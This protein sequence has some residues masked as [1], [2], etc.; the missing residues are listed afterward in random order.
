MQLTPTTASPRLI[1]TKCST[2][3]PLWAIITS[4]PLS[5]SSP[6]QI[7]RQYRPS[8]AGILQSFLPKRKCS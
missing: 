6:I 4:K 2:K 1:S 5:N 7:F 3:W 8:K